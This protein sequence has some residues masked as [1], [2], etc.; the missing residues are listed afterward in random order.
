M[1]RI[2]DN[3]QPDSALLFPFM[4]MSKRARS[5]MTMHEAAALI[6]VSPMTVSRV[7]SGSPNVRPETRAR[8]EAAIKRIGYTPNPAARH[9]AGAKALRIGVIYNNPSVAY[10]NEFLM[11]I[12]DATGP[13]ECQ[14]VL[15]KC[16]SRNIRPAIEKIVADGLDGVMLPPPLSDSPQVLD[17]L[18]E[19]GIPCVSVAG[20]AN[21]EIGLA[22]TIDNFDAAR[23]MTRYLL[24]LG[25][26]DIGFILGAS[27][28]LASAER[29]A[30][31]VA[32]LEEAG[33]DL[34]PSRVCRGAF[35]YKSGL[36]AAQQL[37]A[38][39]RK[40]SAIFASN[41]DMAAAVI[42]TAHQ[43]QLHVPT[44]LTVV[45]FDDT[46]FA[47]AIWPPLTTIKQPIGIMAKRA[48]ALLID[49]IRLRSAG[50]TTEP[51]YQLVKFSL[52]KR[53]SSAPL[54]T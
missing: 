51:N 23:T 54:T 45:G 4:K 30:G 25:H 22:V 42:A 35:T 32:A 48:L 26:R 2:R 18:R 3:A 53:D 12:L 44:D 20:K 24:K 13:L 5:P 38:N 1:S 39:D 14:I 10:L 31:F 11:G 19:A 6:G 40:P 9:L 15:E 41:D 29:Y 43:L 17:L 33:I 34:A 7:L 21:G 50:K 28:Q 52:I 37:L 36:G 8:V 49:E 27:N 46:L 47:T 16:G